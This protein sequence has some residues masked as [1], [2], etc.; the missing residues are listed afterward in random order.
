MLS[1]LWTF[2][3]EKLKDKGV[4]DNILISIGNHVKDKK[5]NSAIVEQ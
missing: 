4:S 5:Q 3:R 1:P 2:R